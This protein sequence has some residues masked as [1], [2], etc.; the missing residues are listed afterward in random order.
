MQNIDSPDFRSPEV[1]ISEMAARVLAEF[2]F[3][4]LVTKTSSCSINMQK[5]TWP[6]S[7]HFDLM[8]L[9]KSNCE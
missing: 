9:K 4:V 3:R 1:G 6:I 5:R 7:G 8:Q 2:F